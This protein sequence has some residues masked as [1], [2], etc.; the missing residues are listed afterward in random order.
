MNIALVYRL[1]SPGGVQSCCFSLIKGLNREGIIPDII[2]DVEPDWS[3]LEEIGVEANFRFIR[4]TI[5]T[6]FIEKLPN[7][8]RYSAWVANTI[9]GN[10]YLDDYDFFYIFYNGFLINHDTPH[11]RYLPGPPLLPQLETSSPGLRGI[12]SRINKRLYKHL[13]KHFLPV[14]EFHNNDNYVIISQYTS[15]LFKEAHG[16][17]LPIIYPPIN[18]S[19]HSFDFKDLPNRNSITFFSRIIDYK[20]P[21]FVLKLAQE[22]QD[23]RCVIMGG[24]PSYR[25]SYF[26]DLQDQAKKLGI[27]NSV[28]LANPSNQRVK[29]ELS[30][31]LYYI[32]P[33]INEHFGMTTT[34][35]IASGAIP[36]VHDSGGQTEIVIDPRLRFTDMDFMRKFDTLIR[37]PAE[38]LN[39]IRKTLLEH[40]QQYSDEIFISKMLSYLSSDSTTS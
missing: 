38:E 4:F 1:D 30:R 39:S 35:A 10:Q 16:V 26:Q 9:N 2:W 5:P 18:L 12:P 31:T 21:E 32:F 11:V 14:Y 13:L 19:N 6:P 15:D 36:Y 27:K 8:L 25:Q 29:D 33:G 3:L 22:Y 37:L 17:E 7:S 40:I 20:R 34:E 24:V 28:F 23:L